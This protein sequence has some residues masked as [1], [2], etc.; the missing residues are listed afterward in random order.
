VVPGSTLVVTRV[1]TKA[2]TSKY[3]INRKTSSF[4]EVQT[5]LKGR[6]IDLDHKRFLILQVYY[7]STS[8][9]TSAK[10]IAQGEVESIAQMKP[11][12]Q[13][14]HE[15]GLLEYLEDII[16]TSSLKSPIEEAMASMDALSEER[17]EKIGRLR[18]VEKEKKR[19]EEGKK[20]A[21]DY[22][23]L[24]NQWVRAKSRLCQWYVYKCYE[25]EKECLQEIV[26]LLFF[27][28]IGSLRE[29]TEVRRTRPRRS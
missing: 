8:T 6:G 15:D 19:L 3:T 26:S 16:G 11:K 24:Q 12:A 25:N 10:R 4:T 17:T 21:E 22:L 20:E 1:A 29:L 2:N 23:R 5:L 14:E 7:F 9:I 28:S 13:T 18:I 27:K